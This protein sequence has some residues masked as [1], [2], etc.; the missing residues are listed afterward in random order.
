MEDWIATQMR[1]NENYL[2]HI[3]TQRKLTP[4]EYQ[5]VHLERQN[6]QLIKMLSDNENLSKDKI[7]ICAACFE[8]ISKKEI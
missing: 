4:I 6:R 3:A 8:K 1:V 7:I 2:N 5:L